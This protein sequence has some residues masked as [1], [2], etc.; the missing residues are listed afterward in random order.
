M[1]VLTL[2]TTILNALVALAYTIFC[3]CFHWGEVNWPAL[4]AFNVTSSIV[5]GAWIVMAV[6][7]GIDFAPRM[8]HAAKV[9][10]DGAPEASIV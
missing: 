6:L 4:Y 9:A 7:A 5:S 1:G 2:V 3:I 8:W 10:D